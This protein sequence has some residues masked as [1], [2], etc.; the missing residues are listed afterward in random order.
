MGFPYT[1]ADIGKCELCANKNTVKKGDRIDITMKNG[2][3]FKGVVQDVDVIQKTIKIHNRII[4][5]D[6]C[7]KA[8]TFCLFCEGTTEI[9]LD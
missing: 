7:K 8:S 5:F 1:A 2:G 3:S 6:D 4:P 9:N